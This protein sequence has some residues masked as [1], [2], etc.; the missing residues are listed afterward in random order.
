MKRRRD[1][2]APVAVGIVLAAGLLGLAFQLAKP[3][4]GSAAPPGGTE[5]ASGGDTSALLDE[6]DTRFRQAVVMLHAKR[7][8]YAVAALDRV[9]TLAPRL[10]EAHA[11]MGFAL[12]GLQRYAEA[13]GY[14]QRALSLKSDQLNA[15]YGLALC[16]EHAGDLD[17][18]LGAMRVY[19]HLA[20]DSDAYVRKARAAI[21]EWE[22]DRDAAEG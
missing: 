7:F 11:N 8:E 1:L 2:R 21:W 4:G 3:G 16:R 14:F 17:A 10:P 15:Y 12:I 19:V 9:L 5:A 20:D 22:T 6:L 18:A 13:E